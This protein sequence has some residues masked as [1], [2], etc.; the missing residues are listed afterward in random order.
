MLAAG[1]AMN[2]VTIE[3]AK[4][5]LTPPCDNFYPTTTPNRRE[6]LYRRWN[7]AVKKCLNWNNFATFTEDVEDF[8]RREKDANLPIR[9]S[10][11]CSIFLTSAF[12]LFLVARYLQNPNV[13]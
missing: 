2:V 7:Y 12:V 5:I 10:I 8:N 9:Q 3:S 6:I 11:P 1:I 13:G 4:H